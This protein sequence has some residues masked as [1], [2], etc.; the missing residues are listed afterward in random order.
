MAAMFGHTWSSQYGDLPEGVAAS[1]WGAVLSG[2]TPQQLAFGL[3]ACAVSGSEFPPSAPR[4][5]AM[6]FGIPEYEAVRVDVQNPE[7]ER[8]PFTRLVWSR[9]DG[10]R[11]RHASA[12]DADA[13]LKAA[14]HQSAE[15]VM[16]GG[17]LPGDLP[18]IESEKP[19]PPELPE[20]VEARIDKLRQLLGA[21]FSER[22]AAAALA[23]RDRMEGRA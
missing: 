2:L 17:H 18:A 3:H 10:Y 11:H 16:A 12:R 7:A 14:Y 13:M 20:T 8:S 23:E 4:F 15:Y 9:V 21:D 5:R 1:T 19:K 22:A 6:C